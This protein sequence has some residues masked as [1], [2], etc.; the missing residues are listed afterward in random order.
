M[1]F[2]TNEEFSGLFT[3]F[4][5]TAYR[6][7][8]RESYVGASATVGA[9][10]RWMAGEW[11]SPD[12]DHIWYQ[13]VRAQSAAGKRFARVRV[14]SEPWSVYSRYGLW[15]SLVNIE[16][17][18]DIRYL[19]R[20]RAEAANLPVALPGRDYWLFDSRLLVVLHFDDTTND[21]VRYEVVEDPATIVQHN[22][23]RDTAWHY[24]L[25]RDEY[26]GQAGES[27][28]PPSPATPGAS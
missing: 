21:V 27:V 4:E 11:A 26:V 23:W 3:T 8:P 5:H 6:L 15:S 20:H 25:S 24:A 1:A 13:N 17:G 9:F 2:L 7:E 22:Y 19:P 14:V 18:E 12:R 28:E 10:A 16:A